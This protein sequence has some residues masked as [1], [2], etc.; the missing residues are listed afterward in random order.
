MDIGQ[1][2]SKIISITQLRRD[3]DALENVLAKEEEA[4]VMRNQDVIFVAVSPKR[5]LEMNAKTS[6][7]DQ[8]N[9][10]FNIINQLRTSH[11]SH[12]PLASDFVIRERDERVKKWTK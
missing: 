3:I 5:Y 8:I 10:A 2:N 9:E 12:K 7:S 6:D 1:F 4:V 11:K